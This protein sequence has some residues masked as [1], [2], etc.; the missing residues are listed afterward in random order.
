MAFDNITYFLP[1]ANYILRK[2]STLPT[3]QGISDPTHWHSLL[4]VNMF[5]P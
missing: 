2:Q 3:T 4:Y 5:A 1:G